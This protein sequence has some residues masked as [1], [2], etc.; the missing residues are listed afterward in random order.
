MSEQDSNQQPDKQ[1]GTNNGEELA[2]SVKNV[3]ARFFNYLG[4]RSVDHWLFFLIGF[5]LGGLIL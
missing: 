2:D 5:I 1:L 3:F 4:E